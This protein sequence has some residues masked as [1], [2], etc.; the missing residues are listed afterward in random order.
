MGR[1]DAVDSWEFEKVNM[2]LGGDDLGTAPGE[3]T[4]VLFAR[5]IGLSRAELLLRLTTTH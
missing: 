5:N 3:E 1:G 2:R 4:L